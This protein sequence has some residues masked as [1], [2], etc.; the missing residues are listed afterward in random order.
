MIPLNKLS[1]ISDHLVPDIGPFG[2]RKFLHE[3]HAYTM[4]ELFRNLHPYRTATSDEAETVCKI[5]TNLTNCDKE[6]EKLLQSSSPF[7][8]ILTKIRRFFGNFRSDWK[9]LREETFQSIEP[10]YLEIQ[11]R[12]RLI[13]AIQKMGLDPFFNPVE[14]GKS[15]FAAQKN[16]KPNFRYKSNKCAFYTNEQGEAFIV[17]KK[18]KMKALIGSGAQ[19]IVIHALSLK[20]LE[21]KA[22]Y[23]SF[24]TDDQSIKHYEDEK[25]ALGR[26]RHIQGV[27]TFHLY[28]QYKRKKTTK[29][30]C[31]SP[32]Y[33]VGDL[34]SAITRKLL[35]PQNKRN[36]MKSLIQTVK[37]VHA[38]NVMHRDIKL[39]NIFLSD[40]DTPILA[41]LG[42]IAICEKTSKTFKFCCGS[43]LYAS[44]ELLFTSVRG[45]KTDVWSLGVTLFG[46]FREFNPYPE[47]KGM[48]TKEAIKEALS[49]LDLDDPYHR[50]IGQMLIYD[51]KARPSL[52]Q[53]KIP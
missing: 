53:I 9:K 48:P 42:M 21:R 49:Y 23:R 36:I 31:I 27:L 51:Y 34:F 46:L 4:Q 52:D 39:E 43:P 3:N 11:K 15:A 5:W 32:F 24:L 40:Y 6:G 12:E 33:P 18:K 30:I 13:Q 7:I 19:S 35:T 47:K 37:Q 26:L 17:F 20:T 44:P 22:F 16:F 14:I 8:Q 50:V 2:G 28:S 25:A 45:L 1:Q 41:D 29:K 10:I 38:Q